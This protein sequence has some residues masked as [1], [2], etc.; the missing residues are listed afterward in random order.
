MFRE[1]S[2]V[3][4]K[5]VLRQRQ[6]GRYLREIARGVGLDRK[7]IRRYLEVAVSAGFDPSGSE[8]SDEVV[9]AVVAQLRPGRPGGVG[10]GETWFEL[11]GQHAFLKQ[12]V[13]DGLKLTKI[14]TLLRRRGAEVPG[15][16]L[17]LY[18]ARKT[19]RAHGGELSALSNKGAPGTT[20]ELIL[21]ATKRV[22]E[23]RDDAR[24]S[25]AQT[26]A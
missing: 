16:G 3:E 19:A 12:K 2:M 26:P 6:Q 20:F 4:V 17:G 13:D 11:E 24:T 9:S 8:V 1:V 21:P 7:T 5:E 23:V 25:P 10:R 18:V 15:M 14:R 22:T